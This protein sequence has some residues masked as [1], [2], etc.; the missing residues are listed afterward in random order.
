MQRTKLGHGESLLATRRKS[1]RQPD[2]RSG[3]VRDW[4]KDMLML[5]PLLKFLCS[6]G[7]KGPTIPSRPQGPF[8]VKEHLY[9]L[10]LQDQHAC[11]EMV[12]KCF[13]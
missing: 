11:V 6:K 5:G 1:E 4:R 3:C 2:G 8:P 10:L 9:I 13:L 7:P 12:V